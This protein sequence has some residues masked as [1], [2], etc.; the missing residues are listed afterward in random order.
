MVL[1]CYVD[2]DANLKGRLWLLGSV[3]KPG[4]RTTTSRL[5]G[6]FLKDEA[7]RMELLTLVGMQRS[8][9]GAGS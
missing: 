8:I 3:R 2:W 6:C 9:G 1:A 5:T 7:A 4:S